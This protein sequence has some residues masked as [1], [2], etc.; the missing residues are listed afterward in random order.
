MSVVA[1]SHTRARY[2]PHIHTHVHMHTL[3]TTDV[4]R[5]G[6]ARRARLL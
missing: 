4:G 6:Q 2:P 3:E 5:G 1:L